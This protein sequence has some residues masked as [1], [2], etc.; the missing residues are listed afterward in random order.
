MK[1]L[2]VDDHPVVR[3]GIRMILATEADMSD[4]T[5]A[6]NAA[7]AL[8]Q[9]RAEVFDLVVLD[10][11]LPDRNGFSV[12]QEIRSRQPELPV[13]IM[14]IQPEEHMAIRALK[15]GASGFLNKESAPEEMVK[16]V[17]TV[18]NGKKYISPRLAEWLALEVSGHRES[19]PHE[20]LSDR[21][22]QVMCLLA[23]GKSIAEIAEMLSR[24]PNTIST[25][26]ARILL[27][28]GI[29]NNA[30]LTQYALNHYLIR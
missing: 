10:I 16:A 3:H 28:M 29:D 2:I 25:Y 19:L 4:C 24:S 27:K 1:I 15:S 11:N 9:L 12:L 30:S 21:E 13:L 22:Y 18:L 8:E 6:A 20:R 26:R 5:E 14:S 23:S 17:R 7:T